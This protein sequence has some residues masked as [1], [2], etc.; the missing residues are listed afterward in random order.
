MS[1]FIDD[2]FSLL[3]G[4]SATES[5]IV[6]AYLWSLEVRTGVDIPHLITEIRCVVKKKS[7]HFMKFVHRKYI[8]TPGMSRVIT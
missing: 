1:F 8:R 2:C 7:N 6:F 4:V 3:F 5:D